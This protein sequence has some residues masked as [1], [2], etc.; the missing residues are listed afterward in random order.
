MSHTLQYRDS[1]SVPNGTDTTLTDTPSNRP[2]L[3]PTPAAG[4]AGLR[5]RF[6]S[7]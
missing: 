5:L 7:C 2:V 6:A 4:L 1:L 3:D